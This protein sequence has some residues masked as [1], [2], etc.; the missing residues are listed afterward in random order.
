LAVS[1]NQPKLCVNATWNKNG[2]T[3]ANQS[4]V[5]KEPRGIFVDYNDT[6]YVADYTKGRILV[7]FKDSTSPV[8]ELTV[9]LFGETSLFVTMNGDIYYENRNE[10]GRIERWSLNSVSS[11][12]VTKFP[13]HCFGLFIDIHNTLYC[14]FFN[15]HQVGSISLDGNTTLMT[16]VAG[17]GSAESESNELNELRGIFVDAN[18]NLYVADALNNRIQL[19]PRGQS[20]GITVAGNGIPNGLN[21]VYPTDV[22]LDSDGF[23][24]IAENHKHRI[25]RSGRNE[26]ECIVGCNGKSGSASDELNTVYALRFDSYGNLYV[27]DEHNHRIQKFNLATNSCGK[28]NRK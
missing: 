26:F 17:S 24:Y 7:W 1:Y 13:T 8:R 15:H 21:L 20:N 3:F 19:F 11:V 6:I 25:I 9:P 27:A 12:F 18:T 16:I 28:P 23:L 4:T 5:G 2:I 14:S 22:I 10:T